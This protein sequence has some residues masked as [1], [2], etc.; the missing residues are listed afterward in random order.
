MKKF[1]ILVVDDE[2]NMRNLLR[3][4]LSKNGFEVTEANSGRE[5]LTLVNQRIFDLII[6][7]IMMPDMDGWEVCAKIRE[8]KPGS[9]PVLMLTAR[10][11]TKDKVRGLNAGADD[12]LVKPFDPEELIARIH[13]LIR[14]SN[15]AEVSHGVQPIIHLPEMTIDFE[16]RQILVHQL[17]VDFTPKEFDLFHLLASQPTRAFSRDLLLERIWGND[18]FGDIRTVDTH[19]KNIREKVRKAGLSYVPIQTLWGVGYKFHRTEGSE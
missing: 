14:R 7:D 1:N 16:G 9:I 19:V 2:W 4:Y 8:M 12:Y 13:A 5:A 15:L 10:M 6:L 3:I 18:Y 17:P 11:D